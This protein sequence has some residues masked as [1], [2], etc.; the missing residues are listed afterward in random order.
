MMVRAALCAAWLA[1]GSAAFAQERIAVVTTTTDLRSLTEAVGG[2]RV[3][4]VSLVPP[5][6]DAEEYQAK[7][8]DALRLKSARLFV[9]VGLDYD[10][11]ADRLLAQ[12]GNRA[13]GRGGP[14]YVDASYGI[15]ALELRGMSVGPGDGHA[16][17]NGNPH[18]WLDPKNAEVITATIL[19]ALQRIDPA[20]AAIYEAN[21]AAFLTRLNTKLTAWEEKLASLRAMPIVAYHNS[22]PYFARR[23]RLD[24]AAFIET[25][26]GVPPS[27]SHLAGIVRTMKARNIR[28]VVREPHEPQR[29]VA[30]VASKAGAAVVTL[31][32]SVGAL[33]QASDY[34]A[35]FDTNVAALLAAGQ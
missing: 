1:F 17:G 32:A 10:L 13:I 8:Q 18:Y 30:F 6:M 21:R 23:F 25:K 11:W 9:R 27:P 19:E 15:A 28:I 20:N 7:P 12:A 22:W 16:H 2:E 4:A 3:A 29:D 26:P 35:L 34:I 24:F 5:T 14:G 33:P 31:A